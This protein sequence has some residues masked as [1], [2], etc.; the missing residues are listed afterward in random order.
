M[1]GFCVDYT[2]KYV[3]SRDDFIKFM[4]DVI[5]KMDS[6]SLTVEDEAIEL[7]QDIELEYKIKYDEDVEENKLSIKVCWLNPG[8]EVTEDEDE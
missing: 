4:R 2:E 8:A 3:G 7:P 5:K 6:R 1:E